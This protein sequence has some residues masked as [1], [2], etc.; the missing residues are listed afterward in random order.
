MNYNRNIGAFLAVILLPQKGYMVSAIGGEQLAMKIF[1]PVSTC[2]LLTFYPIHT[3]YL[4]VMKTTKNYNSKKWND[5]N[6]KKW[7]D[8]GKE[9]Q[10]AIQGMPCRSEKE[11]QCQDERQEEIRHDQTTNFDGYEKL[12]AWCAINEWHGLY[13]HRKDSVICFSRKL[14]VCYLSRIK[15]II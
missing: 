7:N 15:G 1:S 5:N 3:I 11:N 13:Q 14:S 6:C 10:K 2:F 9:L 4:L 8:Y 12:L